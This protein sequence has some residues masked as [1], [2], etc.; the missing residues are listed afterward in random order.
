M[1]F[2]T[3]IHFHTNTCLQVMPKHSSLLQYGKNY[4][5]NKFIAQAQCVNA[6]K[7]CF[8]N[9]LAYFADAVSYMRKMF[10]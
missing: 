5:R 4:D 3:S 10:D 1:V 8:Q 2:V 9:A 7:Q 6:Q